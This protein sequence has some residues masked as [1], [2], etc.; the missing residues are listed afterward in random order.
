MVIRDASPDVGSDADVTAPLVT[1]TTPA[2]NA[3]GV[4]RTAP[5]VVN[6]DEAVFNVDT[7]SFTVM[8]GGNV[9]SGTITAPTAQTYRFQPSTPLVPNTIMT[10]SLTSAISDFV[11]NTLVPVSFSFQTGT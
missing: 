5:I 6:F 7:T 9:V 3:I 8:E 1:S 2:D 11:G 10:V 4:A